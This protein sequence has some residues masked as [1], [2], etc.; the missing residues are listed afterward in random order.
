MYEWDCIFFLFVG[1]IRETISCCSNSQGISGIA[2]KLS[3][4]SIVPKSDTKLMT[5]LTQDQ[6]AAMSKRNDKFHKTKHGTEE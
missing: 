6:I 3:K 5:K 2:S 4:S 1:L